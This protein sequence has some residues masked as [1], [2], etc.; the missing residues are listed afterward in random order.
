MNSLNTVGVKEIFDFIDGK[1]NLN[2]AVNLIKQNSRRFAKRQMTWF[3]R[4]DDVNWIDS[5]SG[6]EKWINS[7]IVR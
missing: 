6:I 7:E 1:L 3:R 5:N 4:Y 2:E